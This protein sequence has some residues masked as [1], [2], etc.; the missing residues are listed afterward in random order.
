MILPEEGRQSA[1]GSQKKSNRTGPL[2]LVSRCG[3]LIHLDLGHE[4]QIENA[5]LVIMLQVV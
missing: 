2:E 5:E 1:T 3:I 4:Q